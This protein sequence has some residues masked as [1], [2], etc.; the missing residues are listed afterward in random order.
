MH[1]SRLRSVFIALALPAL[2]VTGSALAAD[3]E[4]IHREVEIQVPSE[5]AWERVSDFCAISKWLNPPIVGCQ[6]LKGSGGVGTVR[7]LDLGE[8]ARLIQMVEPMIA[9]GPMHYTYA[10]TVGPFEGIQY[11]G[12]VMVRPGS[13]SDSSIVSWT[14]V[15]DREALSDMQAADKIAA[16][17]REI[18]DA[19]IAGLAAMAGM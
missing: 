12:T 7:Q 14:A 13:S 15:F 17:I 1:T 11:H 16:A 6:I 3:I 2:V 5:K 19:G 9:A 8:D 10:M 4:V 18:Y